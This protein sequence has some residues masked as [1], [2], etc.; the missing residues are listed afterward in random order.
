VLGYTAKPVKRGHL[1]DLAKLSLLDRCPL[2][3]VTF[4]QSQT[5]WGYSQLVFSR[6]VSSAGKCT[7]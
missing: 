2:Y 6:Q 5:P 1:G 7:W 3:R 4:W